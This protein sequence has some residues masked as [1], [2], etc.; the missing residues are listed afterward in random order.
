[1][2]TV[3][4]FLLILLLFCSCSS[5]KKIQKK[6]NFILITESY[7]R[8]HAIQKKP[9]S[10]TSDTPP[11]I[12]FEPSGRYSGYTGCNQFFGTYSLTSKK[13]TL[14]Y[15][16]ST[17]DLCFDQREIETAFLRMLKQ[18]VCC[19]KIEKDTLLI[20]NKKGELLHLVATD[21]IPGGNDR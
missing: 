8:L 3:Q 4:T 5:S 9:I 7:W 20:L 12:L 14:D 17:K 2:K 18:D 6:E 10:C 19:Y 13:L 15:L 16:G 1:M 21:S 11:Y